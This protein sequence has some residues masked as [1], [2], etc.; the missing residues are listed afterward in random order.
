MLCGSVLRALSV[1]INIIIKLLNYAVE[2]I[3]QIVQSEPGLFV[4]N[5]AIQ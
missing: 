5:V 4:I 1:S 2:M 3:N